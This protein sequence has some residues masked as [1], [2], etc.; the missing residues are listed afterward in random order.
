MLTFL[1]KIRRSLVESESIGKYLVYAL[2]EIALVVVGILIAL[3]INNWNEWRKDRKVERKI[4]INIQNN[5]KANING[6]NYW[7]D[8]YES[9][10]ISSQI[11]IEHFE[12]NYAYHDSLSSHLSVALFKGVTPEIASPGFE[13]LK[14]KGF[15]IIVD[16]ELKDKIIQLYEIIFPNHRDRVAFVMTDKERI[17]EYI[18]R[19]FLRVE[20]KFVPINPTGL[21]K[22]KYFH[23]LIIKIN[24]DRKYILERIIIARD[25]AENILE[26]VDKE[27]EQK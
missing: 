24:N 14:N 1:R 18:D 7:V 10:P 4:L 8:Y 23:S 15:D 16:E 26:L 3:Q 6:L 27:L 5:I 21:M 20:D 25:A 11:I 2:G 12:N 22:D 17:D 19:N 9:N 13:A